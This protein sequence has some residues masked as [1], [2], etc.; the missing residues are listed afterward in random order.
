MGIIL[1]FVIYPTK[2]RNTGYCPYIVHPFSGKVAM[3]TN[4]FRSEVGMPTDSY[5]VD[6]YLYRTIS[7]FSPGLIG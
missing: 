2:K 4:C 6:V 7:H 3:L 5:N 1:A